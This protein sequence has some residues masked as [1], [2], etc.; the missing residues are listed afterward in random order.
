[1]YAEATT[2]VRSTVGTTEKFKGK[3]GLHQS[4]AL[5]PCMFDIVMDV[6]T[7]EVREEVPWRT[8]FA[9]DIVVTDLTREGVQLKL[10]R[11]RELESRGL[12]ISRTKKEYMWTGGEKWE[13]LKLGQG[14]IKRVTSFK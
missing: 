10:G 9:D 11:W 8:M 6:K 7:S 1:M 12:K 2:Q 3:V 13:T 14:D 5:D 4:S